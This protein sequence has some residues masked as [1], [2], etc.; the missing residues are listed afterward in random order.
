MLY[1]TLIIIIFYNITVFIVFISFLIKKTSLEHKKLLS[2]LFKYNVLI[3][4]YI[5]IYIYICIYWYRFVF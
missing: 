4:I 3:Y 1:I 2:K 5:Y